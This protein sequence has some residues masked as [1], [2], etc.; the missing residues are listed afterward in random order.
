MLLRIKNI[1]AKNKLVVLLI[2]I[3]IFLRLYKLDEF[4]TF[5]GDQ[6]RDAIIIKRIITL[7][8]FPAIGPISS[9]GQVFLGPF[10]YYLMTPFLLLFNLNPLGLAFGSAFF[11]IIGIVSAYLI[12][13]KELNK[14]TG[15][16][17]LFL[18]VFS[19]VQIDFARF[20]WNPN[21][22]PF[23]SFFT[24]Y[25]LYKL[26]ITNKY[27]YGALLGAFLSFS[28]QLHH[29]AFFL[30]IPITVFLV[31]Y[32]IKNKNFLIS[33]TFGLLISFFSF[34]LLYSP[35][36]I[37]DLKHDFLNSKNLIKI[38]TEQR[39]IASSSSFD[40]LLTTINSFFSHTLTIN[41]LPYLSL[42]IFFILIYYF[43][44]NKIFN[45]N[46]FLQINF[47]NFF[48]YIYFF[49]LLNSFRHP[50]YYGQIYL[51][52]F[53]IIAFIFS[54]WNKYRWLK[55]I[56]P[57]LL[58][59]FIFFNGQKYFFLFKEGNRQIWRAKIIAESIIEKKPQSPY[60]VVP[61]PYTEMDGHIRYFLE[62]LGE[63]P[64]SEASADQPKEL[65]M[66][67]YENECDALNH[68]QWQIAA[69][70]NKKVDKIWKIDRVKIYKLIH[71]K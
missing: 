57:F 60:Q 39:V 12:V 41:L 24:L 40:Q 42:F 71:G 21:L 69:F 11:S 30:F 3:G 43:F 48:L 8:H 64:L 38:F 32:Q 4:V 62:I 5:L 45:K 13:R 35:L 46:P 1:L 31:I 51:S 6:G 63:R 33:K 66:L 17:F 56:T 37:F 47:L 55:F 22:L 50:H 59:I 36:I 26:T 44:K 68:P 28:I 23:F 20:S 15:F 70:E 65:Y 9:I 16:F 27:I 25:F 58:I 7:E 29:L 19:S 67:C 34:L 18:M 53:L 49:S 2:L 54:K 52:F 10:F 14:Q 61:I